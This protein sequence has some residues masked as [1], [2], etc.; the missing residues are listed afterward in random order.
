MELGGIQALFKSGYKFSEILPKTKYLRYICM[1][2]F[3]TQ[4][5]DP[6]WR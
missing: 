4:V 2:I 3:Q 6:V 5:S 1:K